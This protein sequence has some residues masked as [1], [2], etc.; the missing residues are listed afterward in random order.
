[1]GLSGLSH[2]IFDEIHYLSD[3]S[4]GTVW[5]ESIIFMPPK[6]RLLGL[7]A[8]IPNAQE[9]A[10][11]IGEIKGHEVKV[12]QKT[13][14]IVPLEHKVFHPRTG[15]TTLNQLYKFWAKKKQAEEKAGLPNRR[16]ESALS[17][18]DLVRAVRRR[19]GFPC[20]Y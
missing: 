19:D 5:E 6:I 8:T 2:V 18:L 9:L 14:R 7:S 16:R 15:I 13:D 20:L 12:V 4:R 11:W 1:E 3:E 17:H 10:D